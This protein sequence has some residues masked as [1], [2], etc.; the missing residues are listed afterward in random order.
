[1][2]A[3]WASQSSIGRSLERWLDAKVTVWAWEKGSHQFSAYL[4]Q[5]ERKKPCLAITRTASKPE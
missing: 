3:D 4:V 1:M 2:L 5:K